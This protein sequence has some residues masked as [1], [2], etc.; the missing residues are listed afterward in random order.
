MKVLAVV[1]ERDRDRVEVWLD[2]N[3]APEETFREQV[4]R[5]RRGDAAPLGRLSE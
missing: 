2:A 5:A 3:Q 4:D 1:E